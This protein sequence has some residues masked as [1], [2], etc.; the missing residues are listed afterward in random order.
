MAARGHPGLAEVTGGR[1]GDLGAV[2]LA[3]ADLDG[4]V[5]VLLGG[6]DLGHHVGAGRDH[7]HGDDAVVLVPGLGHAELGA[8][9]TLQV[10]FEVLYRFLNAH[11]GPQSLIS[12]STPAGQ[13]E[14]HQRVDRL[15]R[16]VNDVDETLVGAHLEVLAGVL[17]L[18]G[19]ADD[20]VDVLL[21]RQRHRAGH[22]RART[23]HGVHDLPRRGVDH[24][25]VIGLEPDADLLSRHQTTSLLRSPNDWS[26]TSSVRWSALLPL[27]PFVRPPRSGVS[28]H[29]KRAQHTR[30]RAGRCLEWRPGGRAERDLL[31]RRGRATTS[32]AGTAAQENLFSSQCPRPGNPAGATGLSC[33]RPR[34]C[35][36]SDDRMAIWPPRASRFRGR[37]MTQYPPPGGPDGTPPPIP[38]PAPAPGA[39]PGAPVPDLPPARARRHGVP[40]CTS[41]AW[42]RCVR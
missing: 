22:L 19:R 28:R 36:K 17:V 31:V 2:D 18:V 21:G 30:D 13:V 15:R 4:V 41:P 12:M 14:A 38:A 8:Q 23:G 34:R 32:T 16:G 11:G 33:Q 10:A 9:Q 1:L 27:H 25:V 24:L 37:Q 42:F 20:A 39:A 35:A 3:E 29:S 5:A 7:G 6:A 40:P 26:R